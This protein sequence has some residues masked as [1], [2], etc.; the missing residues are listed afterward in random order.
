MRV[1]WHV[2]RRPAQSGQLTADSW[3]SLLQV[4]DHLAYW[5][6]QSVRSAFD[7]ATGYG[8]GRMNAEKWLTRV[9][10]LETVAGVAGRG[11]ASE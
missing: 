11:F 4:V 8:P 9:V 1:E 5:S 6:I 3:L 7:I 2:R 10:F